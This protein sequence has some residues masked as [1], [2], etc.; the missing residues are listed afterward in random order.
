MSTTPKI[1]IVHDGEMHS[2]DW[3]GG[4]TPAPEGK[5]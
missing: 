5:E 4:G 1:T 2:F 3:Q